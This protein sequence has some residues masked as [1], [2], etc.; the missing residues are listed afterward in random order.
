MTSDSCQETSSDS[1]SDARAQVCNVDMFAPFELGSRWCEEQRKRFF[2]CKVCMVALQKSS[3]TMPAGHGDQADRYAW[4]RCSI[5]EDYTE[6]YA[7]MQHKEHNG[8][9][10]RA[11]SLAEVP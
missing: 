11:S 5:T 3:L 1:S 10:D 7:S 8:E 9:G 6:D 2:G 4:V